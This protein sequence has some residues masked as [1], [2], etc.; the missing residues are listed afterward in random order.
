[1]SVR[2]TDNTPMIA[3]NNERQSSLFLRLLLEDVERYSEPITPR[4]EGTLRRS[5]L[6]QVVGHRGQIVWKPE[7]A[8]AQEVGTTR[9]FPIK[10]YTTPGT[11]KGYAKKGVEK[12]ILGSEAI[13]RKVGLI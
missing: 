2:V 1:M 12:A 8:A 5:T 13:M 10:R 7:Y 11:G 6:K 3:I 4:R 9:G